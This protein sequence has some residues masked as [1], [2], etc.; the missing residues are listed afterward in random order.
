MFTLGNI[1]TALMMALIVPFVLIYFINTMFG[2]SNP[3]DFQH[4]FVAVLWLGT[5]GGF[6]RF[7]QRQE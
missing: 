4:W 5:A 6:M 2:L 1:V 7:V 3:Y